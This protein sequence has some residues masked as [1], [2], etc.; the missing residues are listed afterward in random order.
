M[1]AISIVAE[2]LY[3]R[4]DGPADA[5]PLLFINSIGCDH[6]MWDAQAAAL[7]DRHRVI[8]YDARGHGASQTPAGDYSLAQL[9]GDTLVVLDA[10]KAPRADICGLSLGGLTA[11]WLA[12]HAPER[13][14]RLA[15]ANTAARIGSA[16]AWADRMDRVRQGGV[17]AVADMAMER[18]FAQDF[19]AAAPATVAEFRRRLIATPV[20]GYVGCC[21]ALRD[22]DLRPLLGRIAAPTLVIAGA[23]DAS[24]PPAQAEELA[25]G[26]AG[27]SLVVLDAAHLSNIERPAEFTAALRQHLEAL[28]G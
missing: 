1:T 15:L 9:G 27:A 11:Q 4:I 25:G 20:D 12:I 2:G 6:T 13:V 23:R 21:A 24:T 17:Q 19:R 26:V 7:A 22:A 10:A 18:F 8:R 14:G 5:P 3:V 28:H 16:E